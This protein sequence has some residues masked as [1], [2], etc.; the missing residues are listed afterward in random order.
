MYETIQ[1]DIKDQVAILTLNRP[2][3]LNS[4]TEVMHKEVINACKEVERN[5][6]IRALVITGA[7][8]A[9]CAGQDLEDVG[10]PD[11]LN[12][13]DFLRKRYNPMIM[14]IHHLGKPV[15]AAVNG[16]A[17]GAGC[18]LALACDFRLASS[19]ASFI[20]AFIHIGLVPDSGSSYFLPRHVGLGKAMEL[21]I[22]GEKLSAQEA[23]ELGL[24]YQISEP[25]AL[26][27]D[28]LLF[29]QRIVS[30]PTKTIGLI[31]K[32]MIKGQ[33]STLEKTLEYEAYAQEIAGKT[34]DHK[35][36]V[37]AFIEKRKPSFE[38][39]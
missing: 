3:K 36:G 6:Q 39:K 19:K 13:G 15:I 21:A 7:G 24:I 11:E 14:Q 32:A 2:D 33:H 38:G 8:R 28:V 16:A 18:S 5:D 34:K 31:K 26:F 4:F 23:K 22:L 10:N 9:F 17:A 35:E 1:F 25:D 37:T 30:M 29:A 20:E 12:Y 27:N